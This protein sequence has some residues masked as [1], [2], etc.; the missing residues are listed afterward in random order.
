MA[1]EV[2]APWGSEE[3]EM[4]EGLEAAV[5][6]VVEDEVEDGAAVEAAAASDVDDELCLDDD[7]PDRSCRNTL[8]PSAS[9]S[10]VSRTFFSST[11]PLTTES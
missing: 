9:S 6:V 2:V 7:L 3:E 8:V 11:S 4:A 1:S 5:V 10:V